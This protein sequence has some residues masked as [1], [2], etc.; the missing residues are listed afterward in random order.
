[1][2]SWWLAWTGYRCMNTSWPPLTVGHNQAVGDVVQ[3][4]AQP[5][6]QVQAADQLARLAAVAG[7]LQL[8]Q[9]ALQL[10]LQSYTLCISPPPAPAWTSPWPRPPSRPGGRHSPPSA[11]G[12]PAPPAAASPAPWPP[13]AGPRPGPRHP[14]AAEIPA[15]RGR[16]ATAPGHLLRL[17]F[18]R[19]HI[20]RMVLVQG[21]AWQQCGSGEL[22]I[23]N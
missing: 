20:L 3:L 4:A 12:P 13:P 7:V 14:P 22:W 19:L 5:A 18:C 23:S 9:A 1:M 8:L 17:S 10:R 16:T 21:L 2:S 6:A 11:A 15:E